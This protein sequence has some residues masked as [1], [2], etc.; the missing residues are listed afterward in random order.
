MPA[1]RRRPLEA[2]LRGVDDALKA[3]LAAESGGGVSAAAGSVAAR[4]QASTDQAMKALLASNCDV[5]IAFQF[6]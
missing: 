2:A 5:I 4:T 3:E 1:Q 6:C